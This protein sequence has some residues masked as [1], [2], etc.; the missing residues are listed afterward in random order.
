[1]T[2]PSSGALRASL[3]LAGRTR[4]LGGLALVSA[5]FA[6][7][8]VGHAQVRSQVVG[9]ALVAYSSPGV[10]FRVPRQHQEGNSVTTSIAA[11]GPVVES[12]NTAYRVELH[13]PGRSSS[14]VV[15]HAGRPGLVPWNEVL[16]RLGGREAAGAADSQPVVLDLIVTP[17]L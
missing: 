9:I 2:T 16:T 7:P 3:R 4:C 17:T 10:Q 12:V 1:M 13:Q 5:L 8:T 14:S 15:L 6:S 11:A